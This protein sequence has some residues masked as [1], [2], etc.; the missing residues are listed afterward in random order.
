MPVTKNDER[1]EEDGCKTFTRRR[2][3]FALAADFLIA[4]IGKIFNILYKNTSNISKN[5][6]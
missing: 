6:L 4:A 1:N 2:K 5:E 3:K